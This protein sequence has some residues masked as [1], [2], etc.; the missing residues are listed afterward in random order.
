MADSAFL[1]TFGFML[2]L[3]GVIVVFVAIVFL[4]F[5]S[6]NG[7]KKVR[8]GGAIIVGPFPIIFGTD[9]RIVKVLFIVSIILMVF[10]LVRI[11]FSIL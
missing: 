3:V 11:V 10:F 5:S 7:E 4:F 2:V 8:G 6:A 1:A 9:R